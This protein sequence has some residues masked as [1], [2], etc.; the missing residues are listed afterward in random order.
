MVFREKQESLSKENLMTTLG[1]KIVNP[2]A[3]S[4]GSGTADSF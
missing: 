3:Y 1:L 2:F 4:G